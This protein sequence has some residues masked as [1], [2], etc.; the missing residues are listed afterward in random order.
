MRSSNAFDAFSWATY[1]SYHSKPCGMLNDWP[2]FGVTM[3]AY[4]LAAIAV[5]NL[6]TRIVLPDADH[7]ERH[8]GQGAG[9]G[10]AL[11]GAE[12]LILPTMMNGQPLRET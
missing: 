1:R 11:G 10:L 6:A 2:P 4:D 8:S 9:G 12:F 7:H 3:M 5:D